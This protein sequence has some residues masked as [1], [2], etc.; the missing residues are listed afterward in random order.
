MVKKV[1]IEDSGSDVDDQV[2]VMSKETKA[3]AKHQQSKLSIKQ[4]HKAAKNQ[5]K[6][7]SK[8]AKGTQ[9]SSQL[10]AL[11]SE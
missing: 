5:T 11:F 4:V 3:A 10:N 9:E 2:Q 8:A 6:K 7:Q 1:V